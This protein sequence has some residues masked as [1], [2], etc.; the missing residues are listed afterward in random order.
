MSLTPTL[1]PDSSSSR[2]KP[3]AGCMSV[4]IQAFHPEEGQ[5]DPYERV[6]HHL[7]RTKLFTVDQHTKQELQRRREVLNDPHVRQRYPADRGPEQE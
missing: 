6:P 2:A 7:R 5:G 4:R 1:R 3:P